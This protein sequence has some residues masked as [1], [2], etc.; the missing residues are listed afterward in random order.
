MNRLG[1]KKW[2]ESLLTSPAGD[3]VSQGNAG[4]DFGRSGAKS[5]NITSEAKPEKATF[6][7]DKMFGKK[8]RKRRVSPAEVQDRSV[9]NKEL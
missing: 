4:R 1:F 2:L 5:K 3:L 8:R 9:F 7:P 6:D